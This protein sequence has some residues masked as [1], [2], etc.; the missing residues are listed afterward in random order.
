[1]T[2][3]CKI[4]VK[5]MTKELCRGITLLPTSTFYPIP[6]TAWERYFDENNS[7]NTMQL[8]NNSPAVHVWNK[9][10]EK[11]IIYL[12]SQQPYGLLAKE[13]CPRTYWSCDTK[14]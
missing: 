11:G 1:M 2:R 10:S 4:A 14:F 3:Y 7:T 6:Y 8:L 13:Y 9:L 12:N 5:R